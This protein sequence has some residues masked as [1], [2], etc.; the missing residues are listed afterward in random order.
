[1]GEGGGCLGG[2]NQ[3]KQPRVADFFLHTPWNLR[4]FQL[5]TMVKK[6]QLECEKCRRLETHRF[7]F[8]SGWNG[9]GDDRKENRKR[10]C[11]ALVWVYALRLDIETLRSFIANN[12]LSGGDCHFKDM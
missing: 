10:A 2:L 7:W 6:E 1:M 3:I 8:H 4:P 5:T 12:I 9:D 11:L